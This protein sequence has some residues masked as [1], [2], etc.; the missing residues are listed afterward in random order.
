MG[1]ITISREL[2]ALGD[3]T[4]KELA[5]LLS[6]RFVDKC[7]LEN[8]I[9]TY[10]ITGSQIEKYDECKP[11]FFASISEDRDDYLHCLKSAILTEAHEGNC[12]FMG[13]GAFAVLENIPGVLPVFLVSSMKTRLERVK[14]YFQ[15]NE[16]QA[17]QL[18]LQS[19]Q[20]RTGFHKFFFEK[21]WKDPENYYVT[22]NTGNLHPGICAEVIRSF[23]ANLF[24]ENTMRECARKLQE[25]L[26]AQEIVHHIR[27]EKQINVHFLEASL[28]DGV[29]YLYGVANSAMI[30]EAASA[31]AQEVSGVT[32]VCS[33]IQI[34]QEYSVRPYKI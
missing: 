4:A 30:V 34:V 14:S 9:K 2:A 18:I 16:K 20:N 21:E 5:K 22:L 29:V 1:I 19:D 24:N 26:L 15:C 3:E 6:Y 28:S 8:R 17:R 25:R 13:R 12:I 32:S 11:S 33:D 23:V 10:A 7:A 27:Y 31:A